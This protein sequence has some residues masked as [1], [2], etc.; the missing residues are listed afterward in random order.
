M[1]GHAL[2]MR[3]SGIGLTPSDF[4]AILENITSKAVLLGFAE[5]TETWPRWCRV[6]NLSDFKTA[7]RVGLSQFEDLE[8][9]APGDEYRYGKFTDKGEPITLASYGKIFAIA[10]Q[11]II[12]DDLSMLL[13]LPDLMGRAAARVPGDLAY[14][15]LTANPLLAD[16]IAL[17][18]AA[19]SNIGTGAVITV[20][21]VGEARELMALQSDISGNAS[22]SNIRLGLLLV[23]VQLEDVANVLRTSEFDPD[24]VNLRRQNPRRN[25]FEVVGEARLSADSATQWYAVAE[26]GNDTVEVAFLDGIMEP[27]IEEEVG[28]NVDGAKMKVALDVAAAPM[29]HR[30][31]V[32]NAGA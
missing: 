8:L 31:F 20:A 1:I 9:V 16:G 7:K 23:P 24:A 13:R 21:S 25:T 19:H 3:A 26:T 28:F 11:T 30:T 27:R 22:G 5:A 4:P 17:F 15:S 2:D 32:R 10:R 14:I 29:E 12:N 6:G 18:D